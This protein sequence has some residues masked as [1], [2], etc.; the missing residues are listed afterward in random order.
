[1]SIFQDIY[2]FVGLEKRSQEF[3]N[4]FSTYLSEAEWG[5]E[6]VK[7]HVLN[8]PLEARIL[9]LGAGPKIL[10]AS[11]ASLGYE[12]TALEPATSGF[13]IMKELGR[14]VDS[15]SALRAIFSSS[16]YFLS[17]VEYNMDQ[18]HRLF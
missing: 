16:Q 18:D 14:V 8:L 10:S 17:D 5:W 11:I 7:G 3:E 15:F 2:D 13:S 9:E 12:I 1:M 6:L 4:A